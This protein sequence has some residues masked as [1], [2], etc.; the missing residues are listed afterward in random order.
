M[1]VT[2]IYNLEGDFCAYLLDN[3]FIPIAPNNGDNLII[4]RAI[5]DG[6]CILKE[7]IIEEIIATYNYKGVLSGYIW[8]HIFVPVPIDESKPFYRMVKTAIDNGSCFIKQPDSE[9]ADRSALKVET[10]VFCIFFDRPW[11]HVKNVYEGK[12]PY[13]STKKA[14]PRIYTFRLINFPLE[15]G[16]NRFN[17][18]IDY[19]SIDSH[20]QI[21]FHMPLQ[22]GML[23]LEVPVNYL[24]KL[25]RNERDHFDDHIAGFI[26][27]IVKTHLQE[28]GRRD[29]DT[30][31][32]IN[33]AKSYLENFIMEVS[34]RI[35][36]ACTREYGGLPIGYIDKWKIYEET[37]VINK[38]EDE[39][40]SLG[41]FSLQGKQN[42]GLKGEWR[43]QTSGLLQISEPEKRPTHPYDYALKRCRMLLQGGLHIEAFCLLN[44]LLE[45][46]IK[47]VLCHCVISDPEI[48]NFMNSQT[49]QHRDRLKILNNIVK[50]TDNIIYN[51]SAYLIKLK[52]VEEIYNIR[53]AYIH[54]LILPEAEE[55][56]PEFER[57]RYL[58]IKQRKYLETLMHDF[59][60]VHES[61]IWFGMQDNLARSND[62]SVIQ[63]IQ[64]YM[65]RKQEQ[66]E[67]K[68]RDYY[69][70]FLTLIYKKFLDLGSQ[71]FT[72]EEIKT[73]LESM[74]S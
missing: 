46:N 49:I 40:Y 38:Y 2:A 31:F 47:D 21:P 7:P 58:S 34:N 5:D 1:E 26:N 25:F 23:E 48:Y 68:T 59:V 18:L 65:R 63:I 4:K 64:E 45:V 39:T 22:F 52:K 43:S 35:I 51:N 66:D 62:F 71:S 53:N 30:N 33:Y 44:T 28:S 12:I 56:R 24:K 20:H 61:N 41:S 8:Q 29:P 36:E 67:Q 50:Y 42:F 3:K 72:K 16:L 10:I 74:L 54:A 14:E 37:I 70:S 57:M 13:K 17:F 6:S 11:S 73:I 9:K 15:E 19:Y 60:D 69:Q 32:L 27:R 55:Q